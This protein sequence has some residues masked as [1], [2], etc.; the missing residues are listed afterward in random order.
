MEKI[1]SFV[2]ARTFLVY[3]VCKHVCLE[4]G[5]SHSLAHVTCLC[6]SRLFAS[7]GGLSQNSRNIQG[8]PHRS[9]A[10]FKTV[11][12][13]IKPRPLSS[14]PKVLLQS[15][16]PDGQVRSTSAFVHR[17]HPRWK[18]LSLCFYSMNNNN[19]DSFRDLL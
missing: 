13:R 17:L 10:L 9:S 16:W 2:R 18:V 6:A 1:T 12:C 15:G 7:H 5:T 11:L 14:L 19:N 8:W 3:G 4:G